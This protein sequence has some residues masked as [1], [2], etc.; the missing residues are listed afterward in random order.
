MSNTSRYA[1]IALGAAALLIAGTIALAYCCG[2]RYW[3]MMARHADTWLTLS[4]PSC[5]IVEWVP[6]AIAPSH[7]A[8]LLAAGATASKSTAF[9]DM[10]IRELK[11]IARERGLK[12]Y[13]SLRKSELMAALV[14][15]VARSQPTLVQSA[16]GYLV[17]ID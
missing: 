15:V 8:G 17:S 6:L 3:T 1:L 2:C 14:G 16:S 11:A 12:G 10:T 9:V 13:S 7:I 4:M 5:P